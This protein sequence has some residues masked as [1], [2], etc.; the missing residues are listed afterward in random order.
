MRCAG[1]LYVHA[2]SSAIL[3]LVS[4]TTLQLDAHSAS[5]LT[6]IWPTQGGVIA[7]P[8]PVMTDRDADNVAGYFFRVTEEIG[9]RNGT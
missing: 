7:W 5:L 6:Q 3:E 9:R 8:T 4:M 2:F 1:N